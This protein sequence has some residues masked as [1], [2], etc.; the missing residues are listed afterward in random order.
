MQCLGNK[1]YQTAKQI[2]FKSLAKTAEEIKTQAVR[3]ERQ[4]DGVRKPHGNLKPKRVSK[5]LLP[6]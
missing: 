3:L 5:H 6:S 1:V 4:F 2:Y